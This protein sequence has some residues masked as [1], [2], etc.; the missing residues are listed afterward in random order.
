[1]KRSPNRKLGRSRLFFEIVITLVVVMSLMILGLLSMRHYSQRVVLCNRSAVPVE[2]S[3]SVNLTGKKTV[4]INFG[5][6]REIASFRSKNEL[7]VVLIRDL[8]GRTLERQLIPAT[9]EDLQ[10][11]QFT[12]G[13]VTN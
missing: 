3:S 2:V 12:G 6:C 1:V 9:D 10:T 13:E 11:V 4:Q 8:K 7:A 5:D